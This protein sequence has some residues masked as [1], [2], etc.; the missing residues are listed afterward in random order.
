MDALIYGGL[1]VVPA[2]DRNYNRYLK[3]ATREQLKEAIK[4]MAGRNG[5]DKGRITACQREL[6]RRDRNNE[7]EQV[8]EV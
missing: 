2:T 3:D 6:K 4:I 5:K 1:T 7:E 8:Y